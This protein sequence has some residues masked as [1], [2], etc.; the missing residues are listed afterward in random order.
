MVED[1]GKVAQV[2]LRVA[3]DL[4]KAVKMYCVREGITE[5][6]WIHGLIETELSRRAPDLWRS[7]VTGG[8]PRGGRA[9]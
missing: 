3:P 5:Q 4:K 1:H 9:R 2:H 6:A 8:D 7:K